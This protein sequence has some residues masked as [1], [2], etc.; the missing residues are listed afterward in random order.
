M[1]NLL[2]APIIILAIS[3]AAEEPKAEI[4]DLAPVVAPLAAV[5]APKYD[6]PKEI[7][8][9]QYRVCISLEI[10]HKGHDFVVSQAM[11]TAIAIGKKKLIT[12]AHGEMIV[13]K[14]V[15]PGFGDIK[16]SIQ[17]FN[18]EGFMVHSVTATV[19]N[20]IF[21]EVSGMDLVVLEV[22]DD[23]PHCVELDAAVKIDVTDWVYVVGAAFGAS[24]YNIT[25]GQLSAK[26]SDEAPLQWQSSAAAVTGNSGGGVYCAKTNKLIGLVVRGGGPISFFIPANVIASFVNEKK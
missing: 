25:W 17:L 5:A 13:H 18:D 14:G 19:K 24:P 10:E 8:F 26:W 21:D 20:K 2:M 23:L 7:V 1:K 9:S 11:G 12:A 22:A 16:Y 3:C 4:V 15:P 6:T